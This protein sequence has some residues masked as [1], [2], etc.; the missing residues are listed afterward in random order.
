MRQT[1]KR[2]SAT[3]AKEEQRTTQFLRYNPDGFQ[4]GDGRNFATKC[5]HNGFCSQESSPRRTP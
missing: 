2:I 5:S 3:F 4:S 1:M